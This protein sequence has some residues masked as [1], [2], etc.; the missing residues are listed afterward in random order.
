MTPEKRQENFIK[1]E[2]L[3]ESRKMIIRFVHFYYLSLSKKSM[4]STASPSTVTLKAR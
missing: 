4:G 3:K 2:E 1:F